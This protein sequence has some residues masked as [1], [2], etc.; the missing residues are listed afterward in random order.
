MKH[1]T[2]KPLTK[3]Q[4]ATLKQLIEAGKSVMNASAEAKVSYYFA[5]KAYGALS[6]KV[7]KRRQKMMRDDLRSGKSVEEVARKYEYSVHYVRR[8]ARE[9]GV[10]LPR[11]FTVRSPRTF[12]VLAEVIRARAEGRTQVQVARDLG[13]TVSYVNRVSLD[14]EEAGVFTALSG[15]VAPCNT[16]TSTGSSPR[17]GSVSSSS[18]LWCWPY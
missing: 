9:I 4:H 12:H 15:S 8:T 16:E 7:Q 3:E 18:P 5:Y 1:A 6:A 17:S 10:D 14:A 2:G 13:L 11:R